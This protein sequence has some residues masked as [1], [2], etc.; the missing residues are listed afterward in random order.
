[1]SDIVNKAVGAASLAGGAFMLTPLGLP[2][3]FHGV[4]GIVVGGL[5]LYTANAVLK[6]IVEENNKSKERAQERSEGESTAQ[7]NTPG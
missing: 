1:M 5:G 4:S 2:F 6:E 3:L 7:E